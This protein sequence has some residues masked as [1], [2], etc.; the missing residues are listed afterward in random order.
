MK[1]TIDILPWSTC[2]THPKDFIDTMLGFGWWV[3]SR[4]VHAD[5]SAGHLETTCRMRHL[6]TTHDLNHLNHFP[7]LETETALPP[8]ATHMV[9]YHVLQSKKRTSNAAPTYLLA[10]NLDLSSAAGL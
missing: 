10:I 7:P 1:A 5:M 9:A 3:Q 2:E 6:T 4:A 8:K